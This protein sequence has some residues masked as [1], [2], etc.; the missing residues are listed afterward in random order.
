[1]C[2]DMYQM[3]SIIL[4]ILVHQFPVLNVL[5]MIYLPI[6]NKHQN[7]GGEHFKKRHSFQVNDA[8]MVIYKEYSFVVVLLSAI[9]DFDNK[10]MES[11]A[12]ISSDNENE[13]LNCHV[14]ASGHILPAHTNIIISETKRKHA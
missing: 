5:K 1:M 12:Y 14:H 8:L 7:S 4:Q 11:C 2:V 13:K 9:P 6:N 10:S 3:S